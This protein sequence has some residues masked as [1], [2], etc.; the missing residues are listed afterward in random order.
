MIRAMET[1]QRIRNRPE[2]SFFLFGPRGTGKSTWLK[3]AYPD[4]VTIDFLDGAVFRRYQAHPERLAEVV[5][6]N[7]GKTILL[8][9]IQKVPE[10]L[11]EV[12][13]LME[14]NRDTQFILTGSSAR[15]LKRSGADLLSGRA[16]VYSMPPFLACE[17]GLSFSLEE[18][19]SS[20]MLPVV[21]SARNP[22]RALSAYLDVYL[23]E[24]IQ[25]EGLVRQLGP[26]TRFLE[27]ASFSHGSQLV[28]TA[29]SRDCGVGRTTVD[30]YLKIL[31]DL[32]IA[33]RLPV[34]TK[35]AKRCLVAHDKFYFFDTGVYRALRPTGPLDR[36]S[37]IDGMALEG[38]VFQHLRAWTEESPS[39]DGLYYWRTTAGLEVDF[40]LYSGATFLAVEV[41]NAVSVA[42]SDL[43]GLKAF[44][45]DYP[46]ARGILLYR[47]TESL[48]KDG[49][50]ILPVEEFLRNIVPGKEIVG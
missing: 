36:P 21:H 35:R 20:G 34:F 31:Y 27:A 25:Q 30:G 42:P 3:M 40:I 38:L 11:S 17:L 8:D 15:K 33:T 41:K 37:E 4:A 9:E 28:S 22:T 45:S 14:S 24:E 49:V 39:R 26:F 43:T 48:L 32:L 18:A 12:H 19:L 6:G 1:Y 16:S 50:H 13:R 29:I 5:S 10:I 47:G 23:R 7:P 2:E 44:L 46:E